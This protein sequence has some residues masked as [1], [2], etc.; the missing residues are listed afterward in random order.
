M[1][2]QNPLGLT[3]TEGFEHVLLMQ[4]SSMVHALLDFSPLHHLD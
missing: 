1:I 2:P 3:I 4:L